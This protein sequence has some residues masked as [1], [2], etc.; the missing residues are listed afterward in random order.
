MPSATAAK[1]RQKFWPL[2]RQTRTGSPATILGKSLTPMTKWIRN[3]EPVEP[4]WYPD[5]PQHYDIVSCW[6]PEDPKEELRPCLVL[7]RGT[8]ANVRHK[9]RV[10]YGTTN[11]KRDTRS[12][13]DLLITD[14]KAI[15][16][17]GLKDPTRFDLDTYL[18]LVYNDAVF[19]CVHGKPTP[20]L[21][22]LDADYRAE[23]QRKRK[24]RPSV[25]VRATPA[26]P[27]SAHPRPSGS[28]ASS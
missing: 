4:A 27:E 25:P 9:L 20:V 26:Q 22:T 17:F 8:V 5:C 28:R 11:L 14:P 24:L 21:G 19:G 2:F 6:W 7:G 16:A 3:P 13:C 12:H 23:V 18:E 15:E 1:S 10:F